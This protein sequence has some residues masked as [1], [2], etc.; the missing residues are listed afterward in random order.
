MQTTEQ[1]LDR[2][3]KHNKRL[4]TALTM[5]AVAMCAGVTVAATGNKDGRFDTVT[6]RQI[7]V[8]NDTDSTVVSMFSTT[9]GGMLKLY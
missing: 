3:E 5:I 9:Y 1:R 6:A 2:L 7:F 4:T 8:T